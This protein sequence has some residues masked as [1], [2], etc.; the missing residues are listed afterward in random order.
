[1]YYCDV[2]SEQQIT[3]QTVPKARKPNN[4]NNNNNNNIEIRGDPKK[5]EKATTVVE[6]TLLAEDY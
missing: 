6:H 1:V 3:L 5:K 4:N 2:K